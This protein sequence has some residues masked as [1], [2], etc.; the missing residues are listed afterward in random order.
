[1][2]LDSESAQ[3]GLAVVDHPCA[4]VH[5]GD[6]VKVVVKHVLERARERSRSGGSFY[7]LHATRARASREPR[8][9]AHL[10]L[11]AEIVEALGAAED[12]GRLV[13]DAAQREDCER[14]ARLLRAR[15]QLARER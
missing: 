15:E 14:P 6:A 7:P 11:A 10:L 12:V 4:A 8:R 5:A 1:M 3:R 13:F 2:E 9:K